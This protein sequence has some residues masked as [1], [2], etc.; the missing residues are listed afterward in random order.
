M[1]EA[2]KPEQLAR[3]L[4]RVIALQKQSGEVKE[5]HERPHGQH[6]YLAAVGAR[7][8]TYY[9]LSGAILAVTSE[10]P[11]LFDLIAR[12]DDPAARSAFKGRFPSLDPN[13]RVLSLW[14]NPKPYR[15]LLEK[16]TSLVHGA[17]LAALKTF[18][19]YWKALDCV[20]VFVTHREDCEVTLAIEGR[21]NEMPPGASNMFFKPQA[22]SSDLAGR[23]PQ[24]AFL[25]LT[26]SIDLPGTVVGVS[27][28]VD[29][30][31]RQNL[32]TTI[33]QKAA[34]MLG[35]DVVAEALPILGPEWGACMAAPPSSDPAW[36][37]HLLAAMRI[38]ST[39][40][41][42]APELLLMNALNSVA[43]LVVF[44]QNQLKPGSISLRSRILEGTEI[45]YLASEKEFPP[46]LQPAFA[47]RGGYLV[48][49]SSPA[50]IARFAVR[51][52][53]QVPANS[54]FLQLLFQPLLGYLR[55]RQE[56]L[57]AYHAVH[58]GLSKADALAGLERLGA[59]L[60]LFERVDVA[61]R[62]LPNGLAWS[63]PRAACGAFAIIPHASNT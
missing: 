30:P 4:E 8:T 52:S 21:P 43:T 24:G 47:C 2:R 9:L 40:T 1:L 57:A 14:L 35:Q 12:L 51:D 18:L 48:L 17:P 56:V 20:G 28:F 45:K 32:R 34:A 54:P 53:G 26:R 46:G 50:A 37:P 55:E 60:E 58:D 10:E 44:A 23:W 42:Q 7:S 39:A 63:R 49:G 25:T 16:Q 33:E 31:T 13:G 6:K 36:F 61:S 15:A 3:L 38:H 11:V 29:L 62:P 19:L 41:E 22:P 27:E 59:F 5:V